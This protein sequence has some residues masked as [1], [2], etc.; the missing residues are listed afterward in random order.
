MTTFDGTNPILDAIGDDDTE[1][2]VTFVSNYH[3]TLTEPFT[4]TVI[5]PGETVELGVLG[6][7]AYEQ[8]VANVAQINAL[9]KTE[10]L[11]VTGV[12]PEEY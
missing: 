7:I 12:G 2:D 9:K 8:I 3:L 5:P 6:D 4:R 10:A 11:T 1:R